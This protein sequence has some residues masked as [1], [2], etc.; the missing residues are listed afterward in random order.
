[1]LPTITEIVVI[2][3]I[4]CWE[5]Y[6]CINILAVN[7]MIQKD[8]EGCREM[9]DTSGVHVWLVLV[10]AFRALAEGGEDE[11]LLN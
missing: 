4:L 5:S 9:Q 6:I 2:I 3:S 7:G 8:A 10:K 11:S 1:V